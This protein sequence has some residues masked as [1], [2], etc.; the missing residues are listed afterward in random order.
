MEEIV[1]QVFYLGL[2]FDLFLKKGGLFSDFFK[3]YFLHFIK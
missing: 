1:S 3:S 2:S